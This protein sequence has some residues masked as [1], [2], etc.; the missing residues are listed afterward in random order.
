LTNVYFVKPL[1]AILAGS[2]VDVELYS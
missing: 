2:D 1:N